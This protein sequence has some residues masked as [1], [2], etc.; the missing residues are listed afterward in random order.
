LEREVGWPRVVLI[1]LAEALYLGGDGRRCQWTAGGI[2][3]AGLD[4]SG[5]VALRALFVCHAWENRPCQIKR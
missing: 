2:L 1:T 3:F 4:L 5:S